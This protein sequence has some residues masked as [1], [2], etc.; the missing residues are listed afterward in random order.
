MVLLDT[1]TVRAPNPLHL[2]FTNGVALLELGTLALGGAV[3]LLERG[4]LAPGGAA[5]Q[6]ALGTFLWPP[7]WLSG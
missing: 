4:T 2:W 6:L 3:A 5:T 7:R 1:V